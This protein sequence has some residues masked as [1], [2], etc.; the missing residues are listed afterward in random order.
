MNKTEENTSNY[1]VIAAMII[2]IG[3]T[4]LMMNAAAGLIIIL[5]GTGL[6]VTLYG[7]RFLTIT[8]GSDHRKL[9]RA[10]SRANYLILITALVLMVLMIFVTDYRM[11]FAAI[12]I[13][14]LTLLAFID[15]LLCTRDY[16]KM[17]IFYC[18]LRI[19]MI[20]M[21]IILFYFFPIK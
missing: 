20:G 14:L 9:S 21:L 7:Y 10:L 16:F 19:I 12:G 4:S 1:E 11:N 2:A 17:N 3:M 13:A 6:L 15:I 5:T 8:E 18:L